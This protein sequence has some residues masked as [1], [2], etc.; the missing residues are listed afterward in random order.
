IDQIWQLI[1]GCEWHISLLGWSY[2]VDHNA[3][4]TSWKKPRPENA[5]LMPECSIRCG[6]SWSNRKL[7]CLRTSSDTLITSDDGSTIQ[8]TRARKPVGKSSNCKGE[9]VDIMA[10]SPDGLM[11]VG[12]CGDGR[13]RLWNAKEGSLVGHQWEGNNDQVECLDWSLNGAEAAGGSEGGT[14]R[15]WSTSTG[16]HVGPLMK[17]SHEFLTTIKYSP[18]GDKFASGCTT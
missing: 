14:I 6:S 13:V 12:K 11:V 9:V 18:E 4:T 16:R 15:R 7:A 8:R 5:S 17:E 10:V 2:F 3:R 1:L